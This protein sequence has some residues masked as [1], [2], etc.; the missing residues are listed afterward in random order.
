[1]NDATTNADPITR[2]Q[3][4]LDERTREME[5]FAYIVSHD[6]QA[7]LRTQ[8]SFIQ[9][10]RM[11]YAESLDGDALEYLRFI[12]NSAKTMQDLI[13]GL[14]AFSRAGRFEICHDSLALDD[15][16]KAAAAEVKK[17]AQ[18]RHAEI[19]AEPLPCIEG[20]R[21][22]LTQLLSHVLRNAIQYTPSERSPVV[23]VTSDSQPDSVFI[24]I[25][26]NGIGVEPDLAE[27]AFE[28]FRRLHSRNDL[29]SG[30]GMGLA[31]SR[32]IVNRHGGSIHFVPSDHGACIEIHLPNKQQTAE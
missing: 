16:L 2:L 19:H 23:R 12:E 27:Q 24:R 29:P 5:Q 14:L 30:A 25:E 11:E 28:V 22:A 10:L 4:D 20:N 8:M 17:L 6:L 3:Q 15:V 9:L 21:E 32:R 1:M 13:Q 26:D 31:I 7:P 18:E